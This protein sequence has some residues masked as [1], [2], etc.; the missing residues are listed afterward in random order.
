MIEFAREQIKIFVVEVEQ[1]V[2]SFG[3]R[4]SDAEKAAIIKRSKFVVVNITDSKMSFIK[5]TM[6]N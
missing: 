5:S 3:S 2:G 4:N 6:P 1:A